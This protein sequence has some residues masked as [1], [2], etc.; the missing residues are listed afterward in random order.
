[1]SGTGG[2]TIEVRITGTL[3][4][5]LSKATAAASAD[6]D[7]LATAWGQKL[8]AG[9]R[10]ASGSLEQAGT[11]LENLTLRTTR[12]RTEIIVLAHEMVQGRFTR[13][14]G[15]LMVLAEG[16]GGVSLAAVAMGGAVLVAAGGLGYLTYRNIEADRE[17]RKLAEGFQLTGRGAQFNSDAI[18]YNMS[19][20]DR[21]PGSTRAATTAFMEFV[22][23]HGNVSFVLSNEVGQLLPA[24][25]E[26]YGKKAPE[27]A[28]KLTE[29]LANL[30]VEGFQK[31]D[32][33]ML[34]LNPVQYETI[35]NLIRTG[36]EAKAVSEILKALSNN[37][38]IY[39]KSLGDQVFDI[40]QKI[41]ALK[42]TMTDPELRGIGDTADVA[43]LATLQKQLVELQRQQATAGQ[44][45]G[46]NRYKAEYDA[47]L[48]I[49]D[50]LK[51]RENI[52][53]SIAKLDRDA[54]EAARRGDSGGQGVF[55][56]ARQAEQ[57]RLDKFDQAAKQTSYSLYLDGENTKAALYREGSAQRLAILRQELAQATEVF[58][59]ES[60]QA[61]AVQAQ[62]NANERGAGQQAQQERQKELRDFEQ[63]VREAARQREAIQ[64][65]NLAT[66]LSLSRIALETKKQDLNREVAENQIT[67]DQ[68]Y[69]ILVSLARQEAQLDIDELERLR[70]IHSE[71]LVEYTRYTN[72][73]RVVRAKLDQDLATM[74]RERTTGTDKEDKRREQ[75][76]KGMVQEITGAEDRLVGDI[77]TKNQSLTSDLVQLGF[78]LLQHEIANDLKYY[79]TKLL[80]D[81]LG[82]QADTAA[83]QGGLLIHLLGETQ[84]TAG[85]VAG[86][87]A[88]AAVKTTARAQGAAADV[89]IGSAS[90]INDAYKSAAGAYSAV[91]GIPVI[92]PILAPIAAG[93]AFAAVAAFDTLTSFD[94]GTNYVPQDMVA[95]I[96]KGERIIPAA[97]N[98]QL[99]NAAGGGGDHYHFHSMD[100][101]S[102]ERLFR[103]NPTAFAAG[104]RSAMQRLKV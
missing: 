24:F 71:D 30:T 77:F 49:N 6:I 15:S 46:Q 84:K 76:Y 62:I 88:R 68:K 94:V 83:S 95:K 2:N 96:H 26:Q 14:P 97:D 47:A 64:R 99:L 23:E 85:T 90:I 43:R 34:N 60:K 38:G 27:A 31:L 80:Y 59:A 67:A 52:T 16:M 89:A 18:A 65:D 104:A 41:A 78:S 33:E 4:P 21:L 29:T 19:F 3:D 103:S 86:E 58:G 11:G 92:G 35:E 74:D 20:L 93:T 13:I 66:D 54:A 101:K 72:Q 70:A 53:A 102:V 25:I 36:N 100:S 17:N 79:T 44:Q 50:K 10:E 42:K 55:L 61:L 63:E 87:G 82:L 98:E 73:I 75:S 1:M 8:Q 39:I 32:R 5:S 57:A 69:Q 48:K 40:D 51:D 81:Q 12:A 22:A 45:E 56:Q 7:K 28:G 37:S 91:V 9:A